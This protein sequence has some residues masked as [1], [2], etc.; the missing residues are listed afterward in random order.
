M[1]FGVAISHN[2]VIHA[3]GLHGG[4][5]DF[6]PS[7]YTGPAPGRWPLVENPLVF[8]NA[9]RDIEGAAP[10]PLCHNGGN[11]VG[12]QLGTPGNVTNAVLYSNLCQNVATGLHDLGSGTIRLCAAGAAASCE[13]PAR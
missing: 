4:A 5:V 3:D 8:H 2:V 6:T 11:R 12:I 13:C 10:R 1:G 9:L 7:W